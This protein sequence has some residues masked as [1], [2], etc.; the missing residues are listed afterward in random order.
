M[1]NIDKPP[2]LLAQKELFK[3]AEG[4]LQQGWCQKVPARGVSGEELNPLSPD[5]VSRCLTGALVAAAGTLKGSP[6]YNQK[7]L[8]KAMRQLR[9]LLLENTLEPGIVRITLIAWNDHPEREKAQVLALV[10]QARD[11]VGHQLETLGIP[12][13]DQS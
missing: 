9:G 12:V 5:A 13:Y 11:Q 7:I 6:F 8:V 4:L 10:A 2:D 3:S 1:T